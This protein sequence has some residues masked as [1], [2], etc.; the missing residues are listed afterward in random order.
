[1]AEEVLPAHL[2]SSAP[3]KW[4]D[5]YRGNELGFIRDQ[6]GLAHPRTGV[7]Q[8]WEFQRYLIEALFQYRRVVVSSSRS[9]SKTH[10]L[11]HL[12]PAFLYCE[13]SRVIV[14]GPTLRQIIKNAMGEA[15]AAMGKCPRALF[16]A[17][18]RTSQSSIE[19]DERH[20]AVSLPAKN[21]DAMRGFHASPVVP[22]DPDA[23]CLSEEDIAWFKE[24]LSDGSTRVLIVIDEA[25]GVDPEAYRAL[26]GM[27]TKPNVFQIWTGNPTLGADEDHPYVKAFSGAAGFQPIRVSAMPKDTV[28]GPPRI[29]YDKTFDHVPEYL[30]SRE[31]KEAALDEYGKHDPI[32][33]SD[34][35]GTFAS[36]SSEFNVVPRLALE[37]AVA[38]GNRFRRP[39]GPRIG[40]DI[41]GG[42]PDMCVA[43]LLVDGVKRGEHVWAPA[44]GSLEAMA[45]VADTIIALALQWGEMVSESDDYPSWNGGAITGDRVSVDDS[46]LVGVCDFMGRKGF[47]VDRVNFASG[48]QGQWNDLVGTQRFLNVRAEMHWVARRGLQEGVFMIPPKFKQSWNQATWTLFE[49]TYDS[50]G[51]IVKLEK[52]IDVKKRHGRS[53]DNWDA[54]I[55]AMRETRRHGNLG[56]GG[57]PIL[58]PV[59]ESDGRRR[60]RPVKK[61][62]RGGRFF[63]SSR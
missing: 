23:D 55:L 10:T 2:L 50:I 51:P 57:P 11:G 61:G 15:R 47:H 33:I 3:Q 45:E 59:D 62:K 5:D 56:Q 54:D 6:L 24:Q 60:I 27:A 53:P 40:V 36:G 46:A 38:L 19:I 22:G 21:P 42:S 13:P 17:S 31:D 25:P 20:W 4:H 1:M 14:V 32:F 30:V 26:A 41:G 37:T 49:R 63:P 12:I 29:V 48:A 58:T 8:M 28:P 16:T 39:L 44:Q 52:K 43:S 35:C 7:L 18:G 34:W 9:T